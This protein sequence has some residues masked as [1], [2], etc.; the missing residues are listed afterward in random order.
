MLVKPLLFFLVRTCSN[1]ESFRKYPYVN[2]LFN[3]KALEDTIQIYRIIRKFGGVL[4]DHKLK[5]LGDRHAKGRINI[6]GSRKDF[7]SFVDEILGEY[8]TVVLKVYV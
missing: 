7:T 2:S 8:K 6:Y 4:S 3:F 1:Y 5:M